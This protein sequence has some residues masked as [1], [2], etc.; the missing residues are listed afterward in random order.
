MP[1]P[2]F[3][4]LALF[5][6]DPA[7]TK[8]EWTKA[9]HKLERPLQRLN[10]EA[11]AAHAALAQR[12]RDHAAKVE[13]AWHG[14]GVATRGDVEPTIAAILA[15]RK[16]G[17]ASDD[18]LSHP[19][20]MPTTKLPKGWR[21]VRLAQLAAT[22]I[23]Y[24]A[25]NWKRRDAAFPLIESG[26]LVAGGIITRAQSYVAVRH[27]VEKSALTIFPSGTLLLALGGSGLTK[28]TC[29][30][31]GIAACLNHAIAAII[32]TRAAQRYHGFVKAWLVDHYDAMRGL[33]KPVQSL[34]VEHVRELALPLPPAG[35]VAAVLREVE[36]RQASRDEYL[37]PAMREIERVERARVKVLRMAAKGE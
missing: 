5:G 7:E 1:R 19:E 10:R 26:D 29:C 30:E 4:P 15:E 9:L 14:A 37:A 25:K 28:G 22:R 11:E 24:A 16:A 27:I 36:Q 2:R 3:H 32:L 23:G 17:G 33:V 20:R 21:Y 8:A 31:L 18:D 34:T 12:I 6:A 13:K 35:S